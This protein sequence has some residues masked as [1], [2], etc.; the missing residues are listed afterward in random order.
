LLVAAAKNQRNP[1]FSGSSLCGHNVKLAN[2]KQF[3]RLNQVK[4]D[5]MA[6]LLLLINL[7]ALALLLYAIM[8]HNANLGRL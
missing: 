4:E 6:L 1:R 8:K 7:D 5:K 3:K 2:L